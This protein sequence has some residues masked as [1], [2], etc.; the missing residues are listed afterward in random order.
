MEVG[1][2]IISSLGAG[3]GINS[4]SI[5]EQLVEIER[6]SK[7]DPIDA[8]R[9]TY[10]T[11]ISDYGL[12]R[13]ALSLLQESADLLID[14]DS[15]GAKNATFTDSDAL[16]PSSLDESAPVG[17]YSFEVL[18]IASAQSISTMAGFDTINDEVGEGELTISLG[19]WDD[20]LDPPEAFTVN[21]D[22][23]ALN[24]TIDDT[25]NTLTGL[26]DEINAKA[27]EADVGLQATIINDGSS[28]RLVITAESGASNEIKISVDEGGLAA[29]NLDDSGL[30]RFAFEEGVAGVNQQMSQNQTGADAS[31]VVNGLTVSRSSNT[32]DDVLEG[33]EFSLVS[34]APGEIMSISIFE[35]KDS[36]EEAARGFVDAYNAFLEAV[37]VLVGE[38][39]ETEEN[40]SLYRDSTTN[41][42]LSSIRSTIASAIPGLENDYTSLATIGIR[43][44][45]DGT[46]SIDEDTFTDAF[47]DNFDLV[48]SLFT[49]EVS[50]SNS[51]I[52]VTGFG[53]QT[54]AGNYDVVITQDPTKALLVGSASTA[55]LSVAA[56]DDYDFVISVDGVTSETISLTPGTYTNDELASHIQSQINNDVNL[57]S[58]RV[59]VAVVWDT[60]HFEITS[61][62]Y[63]AKG[64]ISITVSGISAANLGLDTGTST[65]G[66]DVTGT[67]DGESGFGIA[68]VLL[69]TLNSDPYGLTLVVD[70]G[71]TTSTVSFSSGFGRELSSL[72][73][74]VLE[75]N[76]LIEVREDNLETRI[77]ELDDDEELAER[78]IDAY[79]ARLLAQYS[80]MEAI[81]ASINSSG[82]TLDGL[83]EILSFTASQS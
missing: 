3:S 53:D 40:G 54:V 19:E 27:A 83:F 57:S 22:I 18:A 38:D 5:V 74:S 23:D 69:P 68:N 17:D 32:I 75:S 7:M 33:F 1:S 13:S 24:I 4:G 30:S 14:G 25:N 71:A 6:T 12:M 66:L 20:T 2:D 29:D 51:G 11:Q 80:A 79:E 77:D 72:L 28:Y 47:D 44:E 55:D 21:A 49:P 82:D 59:D 26:R 73:D 58:D 81:V 56:A 41:S 37:E 78:R 43:T 42:I 46:M 76:G 50:S 16:V 52:T 60:D 63:G 65:A 36:A 8:K 48:K 61:N 67:I 9:D 62:A 39:E 70:P 10:E 35:D 64:D 31:I 15:F 45:L 34:A